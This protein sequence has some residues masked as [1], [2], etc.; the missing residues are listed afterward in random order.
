MKITSLT[1]A[2]VKQWSKYKEKKYREID[3]KFLIEGEHLLQEAHKEGLIECVISVEENTS[4]DMYEHY[5]ITSDIM[6]KLSSSVS[7][8][9]IMALCHYP[10]QKETYGKKI[11]ILDDVQDPGN[12]GTIIRSA[13]SFGYDSIILSKGCA[14]VYNE[15]VIRSTQGACF[16]I[17]VFRKDLQEVLTDFKQQGIAVY[18]TALKNA[19]DLQELEVKSPYAFVFGNEGQGVSQGIL[20]RCDKLVKIE[21]ETF[22]SLN[23]AVAAGICMYTCNH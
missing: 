16:H 6:K 14:D 10:E 13:L 22:E 9:N 8:S 3:K 12:L 1:N 2:K 21:M 23:V 5:E 17:P 4:W 18:G 7:G 11:I 19:I 15:K 20:N